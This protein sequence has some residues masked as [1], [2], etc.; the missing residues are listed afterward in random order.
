MEHINAA[1]EKTANKMLCLLKP[2]E[3][4]TR[5]VSWSFGESEFITENESAIA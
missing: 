3:N 1:P 2:S 5:T 4:A